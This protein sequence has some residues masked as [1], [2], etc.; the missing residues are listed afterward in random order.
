MAGK[1]MKPVLQRPPGYTDPN[2]QAKPAP[3]PLPTKA[4]LPPSFEPRKRRSRHCRLCLCCLSLLLIIA[5]LL[6][7][8]AGGLFYLWFDPKLPV[9]HLQSFKFSAFNI[10]KRSDGTYLTAKMVARIEVR[11]PNENIIYHF[12]ESKVETT[13]GD[14]EVNLGST[15]LPEFTQGKKNTTSLEIETS[16]NN[17][18]IEDGIGSK[19]LD[20][21][22][23]K[24]LKV[25]MDVKTSIG[26]GVEGVKTGLL[27]VEVVCG[28]VTLKETS[29]E[30]PRCIIST[31]KWIIIR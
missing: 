8:I 9:F 5:I 30:M 21:F 10:T 6:M 29:T 7:I 26:I 17:E 15:T 18:L 23:S 11:N 19:I 22:T 4:L 28:G 25:D 14:D 27:G 12:G 31:L 3:R 1:P 2:L 16:V 20:Q 13:A 24:K